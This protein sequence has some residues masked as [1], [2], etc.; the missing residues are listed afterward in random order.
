[1]RPSDL[2]QNVNRTAQKRQIYKWPHIQKGYYS[3]VN[4]GR[5]KATGVNITDGWLSETKAERS[6]VQHAK[7]HLV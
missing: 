2:L 7:P 6:Q 1:M 4:K 3:T 5:L